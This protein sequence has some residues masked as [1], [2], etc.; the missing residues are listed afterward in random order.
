MPNL[1]T[2]PVVPRGF[3]SRQLAAAASVAR[4][5]TVTRAAEELAMTQPAVSRLVGALEEAVGFALFDRRRGRLVPS[6]RGRLFL[7]EAERLLIEEGRLARFASDLQALR[8]GSLSIVA[9]PSLGL[10]LL[11]GALRRFRQRHAG[12]NITVAL[13]QRREIDSVL[14]TRRFDIGLVALPV[15]SARMQV[16][17]FGRAD[18]VCLVPRGHRL[19]RRREIRVEDLAAEA[20]IAIGSG[21]LLRERT[22]A[23]FQTLG[24]VPNFSITAETAELASRLVGEGLG[25]A[26]THGYLALHGARGVVA[27]PLHPAIGINYAFL[28]PTNR[29]LGEMALALQAEIRTEAEGYRQAGSPAALNDAPA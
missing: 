21:T 4:Y 27:R 12:I 8:H 23:A 25:I 13:H 6:E 20:L 17:P 7:A 28:V 1:H 3:P 22:E 24:L 16:Q 9:M 5:G 10:T 19:A 26:V 11:P 14:S 18:I 15:P 2:L 29:P